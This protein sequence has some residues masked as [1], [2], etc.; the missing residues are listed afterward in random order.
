MTMK[1]NNNLLEEFIRKLN[2]KIDPLSSEEIQKL[3]FI[4]FYDGLRG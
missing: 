4:Y 3:N 1:S 2:S